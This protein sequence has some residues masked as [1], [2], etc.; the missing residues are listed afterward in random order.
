MKKD[1][2]KQRVTLV[3]TRM[4]DMALN[5][6]DDAQMLQETFGASPQDMA[7]R[8]GSDEAMLSALSRQLEEGLE[9]LAQQ[10]AFGTERQCDPRGDGRNG[11]WSMNFVE[12]I[13]A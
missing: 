13:D 5:G 8:A 7:A 2:L 9:D 10:D 11:H 1:L 4:T 3:L 12:G 6:E